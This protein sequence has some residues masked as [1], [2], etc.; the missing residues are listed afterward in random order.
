MTRDQIR[1]AARLLSSL[2]KI[3]A[4]QA[5]LECQKD[6]KVLVFGDNFEVSPEVM[7]AMLDAGAAHIERRLAELGVDTEGMAKS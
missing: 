5:D 7:K 3:K 1:A 2:G 4:E 6:A